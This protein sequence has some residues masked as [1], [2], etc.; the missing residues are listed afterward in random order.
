MLNKDSTEKLE[1]NYIEAFVLVII[2]DT[3]DT[4]SRLVDVFECEEVGDG[5]VVDWYSL[6]V[7]NDVRRK[8][9]GDFEADVEVFTDVDGDEGLPVVQ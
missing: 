1:R 4:V 3:Q 8:R 2:D 7:D 6:A 5:N 9:F